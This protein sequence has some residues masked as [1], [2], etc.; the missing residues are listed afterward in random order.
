[1]KKFVFCL[2]SFFVLTNF[3]QAMENQDIWT[4]FKPETLQEYTVTISDIFDEDPSEMDISL[5]ND[6]SVSATAGDDSKE[7]TGNASLHHRAAV[8]IKRLA[9]TDST[10]AKTYSFCSGSMIGPRTVLTAA[11]CL[12]ENGKYIQNATVYA[13][14]MPIKKQ[15]IDAYYG[16]NEP[17]DTPRKHYFKKKYLLDENLPYIDFSSIKNDIKQE[18]L[19]KAE[20]DTLAAHSISDYPHANS[21]EFWVPKHYRRINNKEGYYKLSPD[22]YGIIV[23]DK[24]LGNETGWLGLKAVPDGTIP[25]W[26]EIILLGHMFNSS[27]FAYIMFITPQSEISLYQSRGYILS[28]DEDYIYH[29]A[30]SMGSTSGGPIIRYRDQKYI[31]ALHVARTA[32]DK[33]GVRIT[34]KIIKA[35]KK[36]EKKTYE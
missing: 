2:F 32:R 29:N 9:H 34:K 6:L 10:G 31:I 18:T 16:E 28:R 22:D 1:M 26:S 11:H 5:P 24:D 35:V 33:I 27:G 4:I 12:T 21:K 3:S 14:G 25:Q 19:A 20:K 23:L 7:I 17:S 13:T 8:I 36:I 30:N 15:K